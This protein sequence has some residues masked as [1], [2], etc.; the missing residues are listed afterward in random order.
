MAKHWNEH[1]SDIKMDDSGDYNYRGSFYVLDSKDGSSDDEKT[2][3]FI[4]GVT[5]PAFLILV[6][7]VI[8]GILPATGATNTWYVMLP[9]GLT[10]IIGGVIVYFVT[11]LTKALITNEPSMMYSSNGQ[12]RGLVREYVFD[13]TWHRIGVLT[14][15]VIITSIIT[16]FTEAAYL[17]I[18]GKGEHFFG[19][20]ILICSMVMSSLLGTMLLHR[21]NAIKWRKIKERGLNGAE[22]IDQ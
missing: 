22:E 9:F 16:I 20:V 17:V 7:S 11:R 4:F 19:A 12:K 21:Y 6:A 13:K 5:I 1:L 10:I 15:A 18:F 14:K 8:G 3:R 2:R